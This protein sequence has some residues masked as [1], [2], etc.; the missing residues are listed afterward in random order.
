MKAGGRARALRRAAASFARIGGVL[1]AV[2]ALATVLARSTDVIESRVFYFPSREPFETPA[3]VEDVTFV[4]DEGL[5]LHGWWLPAQGRHAEGT[6]PAPTV[7]H[8]HGNAGHVGRHHEF[9]KWLPARGFNVFLFD[10]RSYGRSAAFR[11]LKRR[12]LLADSH[13]AL[14]H[15]LARDDVDPDRVALLGFSMGGAIGLNLAAER[16]EVRAVVAAAA[17]STWQ[18]VGSDYAG[19]IARLL[20]SPGLEP[21]DAAA[22][23][24]DRPLLIVHGDQDG[25]VNPRH[26]ELIEAAARGTGVG[27]ERFV[28]PGA[29]HVTLLTDYRD[30]RDRIAAFLGSEMS[31]R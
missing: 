18:G 24:G 19:P 11:G 8:T 27:V 12:H 3:G 22:K 15:V 10:Y 7:L 30:A 14:D 26:G 29:D 5:E 23:L 9:V 6:E 17:F 21:R 4:N 16:G 13:A 28:Q 31:D 20:V 1:A 2:L 25:I